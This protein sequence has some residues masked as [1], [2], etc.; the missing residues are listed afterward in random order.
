V[1]DEASGAWLGRKVLAEAL[2]VLDGYEMLATELHQAVLAEVGPAI[3]ELLDWM[4]QAP[5]TRYATLAPLVVDAAG[6]GDPAGLRL[7]RH[8]ADEVERLVGALDRSGALPLCLGGSLAPAILA[9]MTEAIAARVRPGEGDAC[10]GAL[11]LAQGLAQSDLK[12]PCKA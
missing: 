2:R 8:A 5:S 3:D 11:L 6:A 4:H 10:D 7:M 1:R 9:Y 12:R